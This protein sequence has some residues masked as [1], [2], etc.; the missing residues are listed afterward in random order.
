[1]FV[2]SHF[3]LNFRL[4]ITHGV[5]T[6]TGPKR[7]FFLFLHFP[8]QF[9]KNIWSRKKLQNYTSSAIGDGDRDLPPCLTA[10]GARAVL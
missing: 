5:W 3:T 2:L 7:D 6:G 1:M 8:P 10:L 4:K 9:C